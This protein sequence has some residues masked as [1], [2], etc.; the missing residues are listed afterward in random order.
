MKLS[1]FKGEDALDLLA[2]IIEPAA[3]ILSDKEIAEIYRSGGKKTALV[4]VAIKNHKK[5]VIEILAAMD[6]VPAEEYSCNVLTLP[7]K[8]LEILNDKELIQFFTSAVQT[9]G[10]TSSTSPTETTEANEQ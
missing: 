9:G 3:E 5:E 6:G 4:K 8:L 7:M 2:D 1:E 10:A